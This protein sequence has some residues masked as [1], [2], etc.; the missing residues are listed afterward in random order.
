MDDILA[1]SDDDFSDADEEG[2]YPA[3]R[4]DVRTMNI[5]DIILTSHKNVIPREIQILKWGKIGSR[6]KRYC[7]IMG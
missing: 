6:P 1:D 3:Y 2:N 4:N 5:S 7:H